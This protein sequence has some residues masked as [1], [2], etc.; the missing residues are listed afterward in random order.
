L[1]R[2]KKPRTP[3]VPERRTVEEFVYA[4]CERLY[5]PWDVAIAYLQELREKYPTATLEEKWTG[6][7][8]MEMRVSWS[9]P[10]T[11][12][13]MAERLRVEA[14]MAEHERRERIRQKER[15]RDEKEYVR[16]RTKLGKRW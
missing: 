14:A 13:E 6:Y 3:L 1:S 12:E 15:L 16:L 9:R 2:S 10:E 7:E 4:D 5:G 11:D 8:D